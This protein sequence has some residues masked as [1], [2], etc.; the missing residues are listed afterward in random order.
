LRGPE[1]IY[2]SAPDPEDVS[3]VNILATHAHSE[4]YIVQ[5]SIP[6]VLLP[7]NSH[8]SH[9][10]TTPNII[11]A[12]KSSYIEEL[13]KHP[14][15]QYMFLR[16]RNWG[17]ST[18]LQML[19]DYYDKGKADNFEDTFGQLYIGQKPTKDRSSLLVLIFDFSTIDTTGPI[20]AILSNFNSIIR[21]TLRKFLFTNRAY[22]G[23]PDIEELANDENALQRVLVCI[24][25][26]SG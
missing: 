3:E 12:D 26:W 17:K 10:L 2:R 20:E 5:N 22:L 24:P 14:Q 11:A 16:P 13:D 15:Y 18:F 1:T 25:C 7:V 9:L 23:N 19:A 4:R 21:T 8:F 6:N